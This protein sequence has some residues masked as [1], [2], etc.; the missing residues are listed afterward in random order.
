[1]SRFVNPL[2]QYSSAGVELSGGQLF[3]SDSGTSI[4]KDTFADSELTIPNANPVILDSDGVIPSI[5]LEDDAP[6]RVTILRA[7]GSLF[8]QADNVT[9]LGG[10]TGSPDHSWVSTT[11]YDIPDDVVASNFRWYQSISNDNTGNDPTISASDWTEYTKLKIWNINESYILDFVVQRNHILYGSRVGNNEG[12]TPETSP[13]EW[14]NLSG[15]GLAPV[16]YSAAGMFPNVT[17]GPELAD[18]TRGIVFDKTFN[19][20][21]TLEEFVQITIDMP[22]SW[23]GG[24]VNINYDWSSSSASLDNVEWKTSI[25]TFTDGTD[26]AAIAAFED[27]QNVIDANQGSSF[28]NVSGTV[29]VT[30]TVT[31]NT[32]IVLE[33]SRIAATSGVNLSG[34][35]RL[36]GLFL[37]YTSTSSVN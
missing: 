16:Y 1:M 12:N 20:D 35:A 3:F 25:V 6:Y 33:I 8:D 32:I 31:T 23:D 22:P 2:S 5:F 17:T 34:D 29:I 21:D 36:H 9:G 28:E 10:T 18:T 37:T 13:D 11:T 14:A 19:F 26:V 7:D 4:P 24:A 30:P 27:T 15:I